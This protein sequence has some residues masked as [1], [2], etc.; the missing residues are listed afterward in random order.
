MDK[1]THSLSDALCFRFST[2]A[3]Q[4]L[5][6]SGYGISRFD[7]L[8]WQRVPTRMLSVAMTDDMALKAWFLDAV[9]PLEGALVR[10]IA[11]NCGHSHDVAD[12]R[13]EVY[14]RALCA[15]REAL[16]ASTRNYLFTIARNVLIDRARR[17]KIVSFEQVSNLEVVGYAADLGATDRH[18]DARDQL[19]RAM[20]G[21]DNLP[22]RC[23]DVVRLRKVEGLGVQ[24]TARKLGIS[25]HT[26]E[27][28]LT[29]GMRALTDFML[30]GDGR[31]KRADHRA[32]QWKTR[33]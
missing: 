19:R 14:E 11:S 8:L 7:R 33:R 30:G 23:R 1:V 28:Q 16:P 17:A 22:P 9:L 3:N 24:E 10:F 31:I 4:H 13:Q 20:A 12:I 25:H 18:L 29:L 21:L 2:K 5:D 15:A 27:R 6:K 32:R 26:V